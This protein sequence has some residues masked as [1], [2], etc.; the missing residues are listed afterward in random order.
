[1]IEVDGV[2]KMYKLYPRPGDRLKE[3]L[4]FGRR[5]FHREHWALRDVTLE[6]KPGETFCI[7][8]E[9]G[10]G[11]STL[12]KLIAG[13]L[14]PSA[15]CVR[16][17]GRLT[18]LLELGAGF[19]P[20]FTGRQNLFLNGAIL[21]LAPREIKQR[22]DSILDFAEIGSYFD[23]PVKTYSSGMAMRLGFALAVHLHPEILVVDEALAV[24]D[25]YFRHRCMRKFHELRSQGV[26]IVYVTHDISEIKEIGHRAV[27]LE[28]GRVREIGAVP[29]VAQHYLAALLNQNAE[30]FQIRQAAALQAPHAAETPPE[31]ILNKG[32]PTYRYGDGRAEL[33]GVEITDSNG[34]PVD[35]VRTPAEIVVRFSMKARQLIHLPIAGVTMRTRE[36]VD[37]TATNTARLNIPVDPMVA[38]EVRTFDF[39]LK[40]PELAAGYYLITAGLANGDMTKSQPCD[41]AENVASIRV[42]PGEKPV[43]G[44]LRLPCVVKVRG[45]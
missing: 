13:I 22:L 45:A 25:I 31:I 17:R 6:I 43:Y 16:I 39:H 36:G 24:G 11:K 37:L 14:E 33:L 1:M 4:A 3:A 10:S 23:Q 30:S 7:I 42:L 44:Y 2:S 35:A 12:L 18:A 27:W 15:G 5:R 32:R 29:E 40:L 8:G 26:T 38:G 21:G 41:I 19:N 28:A 34:S 9:N 20:E